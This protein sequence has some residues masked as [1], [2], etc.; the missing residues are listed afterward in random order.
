M[1]ADELNINKETNHQIPHELYGSGVSVQHL[2]DTDSWMC[3]SNRYHA[4][5]SSRLVKTIPVFLRKMR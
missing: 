3:R 4:K 5:A 2:P 1:M